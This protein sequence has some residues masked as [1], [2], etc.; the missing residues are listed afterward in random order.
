MKKHIV[1]YL[2][3]SCLSCISMACDQE[4]SKLVDYTNTSEMTWNNDSDQGITLSFGWPPL[5]IH[6]QDGVIS[7]GSGVTAFY[8]EKGGKDHYPSPDRIGSTIVT[9]E[10]GTCVEYGKYPQSHPEG[11]DPGHDLSINDNYKFEKKKDDAGETFW[12]WTYTFT[13]DDYL[14]AK[15]MAENGE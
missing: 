15:E 1:L 11:Y 12:C 4:E 7:T 14:T 3:V 9:F 5:A 6:P 8:S 13:N 2:A 10:D